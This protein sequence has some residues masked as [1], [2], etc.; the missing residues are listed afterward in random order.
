MIAVILKSVTGFNWQAIFILCQRHKLT[1]LI[2]K[3]QL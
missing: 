3:R 2:E 1:E